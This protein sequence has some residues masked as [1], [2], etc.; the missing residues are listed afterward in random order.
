[1]SFQISI[2][3]GLFAHPASVE[4]KQREVAGT[5]RDDMSNY[6]KYSLM[7]VWPVTIISAAVHVIIKGLVWVCC[8]PYRSRGRGCHP[9]PPSHG[10]SNP[11]SLPG[12]VTDGREEP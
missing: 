6:Q 9:L 3:A 4:C 11:A 7:Y 2:A 8:W 1:M 12:C 5:V 10:V